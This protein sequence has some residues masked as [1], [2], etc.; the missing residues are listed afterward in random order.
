MRYAYQAYK[1][2]RS[3]LNLHVLVGRIRR[4]RRIRRGPSPHG[5][6]LGEG[7]ASPQPS[8]VKTLMKVNTMK[9]LHFGAGNIG[10]GFIGKLLAGRK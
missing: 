2:K 8:R 9:A 5:E 1:T 3:L 7:K 10:R 6:G 4:L